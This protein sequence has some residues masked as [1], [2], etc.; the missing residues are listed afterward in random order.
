MLS[1]G[2]KVIK[3]TG[4]YTF[5][6]VVIAVFLKRNGT[7][8]RYVVENEEGICHIFNDRQIRKV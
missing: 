4:D 2:D 8:V 1:M 5:S 6:G 7:A 3:D